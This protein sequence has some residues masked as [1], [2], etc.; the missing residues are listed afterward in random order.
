MHKHAA[1][2]LHYDLRLEMRGVLQSWAVPKGPSTNPR[3]KRLA[4]LVEDHPLEYGDFEGIIPEGNYGA[5]AVIVWDRGSWTP[6]GDPGEGLSRGK[7]LFQL[8]GHKLKGTWTLVKIKK[9]KKEWLL[10]KERDALVRE[11][12]DAFPQGSV[13]SGLT[14]E[15]LRDGVDKGEPVRQ[16]L[17]KARAPRRQVKAKEVELMLAETADAPFSKPGWLYELKYDGYRVVAAREGDIPRL[18]SRNGRDL[19]ATFPEITRALSALPFSHVVIDGE[20]VVHDQTGLPSFQRLQQRAKL[21]RTVDIRRAAAES[22]ATLYAFDLPGFEEFDL[23]GLPLARRKDLLEHVVPS[24]GVIRYADHI[25]EQG[26]AFF[27][28]IERMRLE[29]MIAKKADSRYRGGRWRDWLKVRSDLTD[30]FVVVGYTKPKGGRAGFGALHLAQYEGGEL[31]YAG[32]VG[33]GFDEQLLEDARKALDTAV[34]KA[35]PCSGTVPTGRDHVWV[36]P[37]LVAEV[38]FKER[39][40]DGLLRHPVFLRFRD[41]KRPEE[42][43]GKGKREEGKVED[44][45]PSVTP[46][47]PVVQFSNL[48][49]VFWPD[50]GYTKGD[51]IAYYRDV[52]PWILPYLRDR[53]LVMTRYPDGIA[54]KSFFQK[55]APV[56]APEWIRTERVYSEDSEREL[57]Y[58]ICDNQ[59]SLLYVANL[60]SI[61]LHVWASRTP[62]LGFPDWASLDLDPKGT[63]FEYVVE[64]ARA[65]RALCDEIELPVFIK[66]TGSSG[67]H[68]LVPLGRQCTHEQ[69]KV[70]AELLARVVVAERHDIATLTRV[71]SRRDGR[72]YVDFL[73]NGQGKLLAAPF[74]ARPVPGALVS[75]P[76]RWSEVT[77]RLDISRYTIRTAVKRMEKLGEDPMR[78]VLELKP[79]LPAV[80]E[81]LAERV[82]AAEGNGVRQK[83]A[84]GGRK[85]NRRG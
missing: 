68:A 1:S 42:C 15:E 62:T 29:G 26:E 7:L 46:A 34:V 67:L 3:D 81:R 4:V 50:E 22:P 69:A 83:T 47:P 33:S 35:P 20:I 24:V 6:V 51:L 38:R 31:R 49:K 55:D 19:S 17:T 76:L 18:L 52:A 39:T 25:E 61:P 40:G 32:R 21:T 10:I 8:H 27:A 64:I 71:I 37:L 23:R 11:D 54:G 12:G 53:P 78:P 2:H 57:Q 66:T 60:A 48:D 45:I 70:L 58:F 79:D 30:D 80:L 9:G 56:F 73:Q 74:C 41:D 14:V 63:P 72:V 43:E 13:L 36:E 84:G 82:T 65:I 77:K 28:E 44:I 5:G 85:R 59:E 16:V 75:M